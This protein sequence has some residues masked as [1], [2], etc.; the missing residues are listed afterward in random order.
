MARNVDIEVQEK[1]FDI[2]LIAYEEINED[3]LLAGLLYYLGET[4][5]VDIEIL[6]SIFHRE[7]KCEFVK[8]N[9]IGPE[10]SDYI[11]SYG[12][13]IGLDDTAY[14]ILTECEDGEEELGFIR[15]LVGTTSDYSIGC[16]KID[17]PSGKN[18]KEVLEILMKYAGHYVMKMMEVFIRNSNSMDIPNN[19]LAELVVRRLDTYPNFGDLSNDVE[20]RV[21]QILS[22]SE[23]LETISAKPSNAYKAGLCTTSSEGKKF[24]Q[25]LHEM[26]YNGK[27]LNTYIKFLL[28]QHIPFGWLEI[29]AQKYLDFC[30]ESGY[31][32]RIVDFNRRISESNERGARKYSTKK[33]YGIRK[34]TNKSEDC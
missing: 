8:E 25:T 31:D 34:I 33:L 30:N 21:A 28:D 13:M 11:F 16:Y 14:S 27:Y 26:G 12:E 23:Y 4:D 17:V 2:S 20:K 5:D 15:H 18:K 22:K 9:K 6:E 32:D 24:F 3:Q 19:N 7:Y 29:D 10:I 1:I